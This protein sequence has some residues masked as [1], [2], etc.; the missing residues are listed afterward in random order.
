MSG[1]LIVKIIGSEGHSNSFKSLRRNKDSTSFPPKSNESAATLGISF[2]SK[3]RARQ[4]AL[5]SSS[6]RRK[7]NRERNP[8]SNKRR[9]HGPL[10]LSCPKE[11]CTSTNNNRTDGCKSGRDNSTSITQASLD[12]REKENAQLFFSGLKKA[13]DWPSGSSV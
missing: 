7:K 12:E 6:S 4:G 11:C 3:S 2:Q 5:S 10:V 9:R 13:A 1:C 8:I